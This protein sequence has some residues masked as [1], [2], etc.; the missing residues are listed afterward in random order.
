MSLTSSLNVGVSALRAYSEGIQ[1]VSNN[2]ANVNTIG[3]KSSQA[4]YAD[5]FANVLRPL[6]PNAR[7]ADI[8]S[9]KIPP[10]QVGGGV[11]IEAIAPVFSQGTI[12]VTNS[13]SDLAIAGNGFFVVK[14]NQSGRSYATR[15]GNFRVD[16]EGYLVT[17]Q[18]FRVQGAVGATTKVV[19]DSSTGNF[20]VMGGQDNAK[21]VIP[22]DQNSTL[23]VSTLTS[24]SKDIVIGNSSIA[25]V[26]K[27]GL[28]VTGQ[29]IPSG[30]VISSILGTTVTLSK[31]A[32]IDGP[33]S[34]RFYF[35]TV[36]QNA[37]SISIPPDYSRPDLTSGIEVSGSGFDPGTE[38]VTATGNS[39]TT[40]ASAADNISLT[41]MS[42]AQADN[43]NTAKT[44]SIQC[45]ST[46][47]LQK[48]MTVAIVPSGFPIG[49]TLRIVNITDNTHFVV[50]AVATSDVSSASGTAAG[51]K[52]LDAS[53]NIFRLSSLTLPDGTAV[54][55]GMKISVEGVKG[56]CYVASTSL[57]KYG[58][59]DVAMSDEA[60]IDLTGVTASSG[61]TTLNLGGISSTVPRL[62]VGDVIL[63]VGV[64]PGT[65]ITAINGTNVTLSQ[66]TTGAIL[67][68]DSVQSVGKPV[69]PV[70]SSYQA[71][72]IAFGDASIVVNKRPIVDS[73]DAFSLSLGTEYKSAAKIGDIRV[74]F[75]EA[76]ATYPSGDYTFYDPAGN[77]LNSV[78]HAAAASGVPKIRTFNVGTNGDINVILS[79]GQ[80]FTAGAVLLQTYHDPGALLR[81]GD[82]LF[83]GLDTAGPFN[84][85][86]TADN[87]NNL[88]PANKGL[89]AING[90]SVEMSN[91]D[92]GQEFSTMITTQRAFQAG[93][94]VITTT[95]QMLE[96]AVNLKR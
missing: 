11:Q 79:N 19:Y 64:K 21:V 43:D 73:Y 47:G 59:Y 7:N 51:D 40:L 16:A 81:E 86:F 33:Q 54:V 50:D 88:R 72:R 87:I 17:Q 46:A 41:G 4:Q 55:P 66:A 12:S 85:T 82:N 60:P 24:L 26:L 45:D 68:T 89:G 37:N 27:P 42:V 18:G 52:N 22:A 58:S 84:G 56:T 25:G 32:T 77:V 1:V 75:T 74:S 28:P 83:S 48:G 39:K 38:I 49:T 62:R 71:V 30:T 61:S 34:I 76:T 93:S 78:D 14:D 69:Y 96:E 15:A 70:T 2:I 6:V 65:I 90:G 20:N 10:T 63:S 94:R 31:A 36:D 13:N 3:Y 57:N 44:C 91:V 8:V 67:A 53:T 9:V 95:D 35:K 29:G 23:D 5:T 80:T 92:L